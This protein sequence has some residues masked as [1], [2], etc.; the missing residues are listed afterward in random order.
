MLQ[1]YGVTRVLLLTSIG[2]HTAITL[3]RLY[4]LLYNIHQ[5]IVLVWEFGIYCVPQV[6]LLDLYQKVGDMVFLVCRASTNT[7]MYVNKD[8]LANLDIKTAFSSLTP[9]PCFY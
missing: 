2:Y 8:V 6:V 7:R 3:A 4:K 9:P 5:S 1:C